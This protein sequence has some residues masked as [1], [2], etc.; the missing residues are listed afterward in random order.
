[1]VTKTHE[2]FWRA[3]TKDSKPQVSVQ[4]CAEAAAAHRILW[5]PYELCL[6]KGQRWG[7]SCVP[8]QSRSCSWLGVKSLLKPWAPLPHSQSHPRLQLLLCC[9][10]SV[11]LHQCPQ[12]CVGKHQSS[13]WRCLLSVCVQREGEPAWPGSSCVG[14]E[15]AAS[16]Q[17]WGEEEVLSPEPASLDTESKARTGEAG[18]LYRCEIPPGLSQNCYLLQGV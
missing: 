2:T 4:C 3:G 10:T 11:K 15:G 14:A 12:S 18:S 9:F 5:V 6:G 17:T 7:G 13:S 1:M 16:G 8:V